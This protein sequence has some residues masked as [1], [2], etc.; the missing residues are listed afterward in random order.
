MVVR[1]VPWAIAGLLYVDPAQGQQLDYCNIA[2]DYYSAGAATP[3]DDNRT[4]AKVFDPGE[5]SQGNYRGNAVVVDGTLGLLLTPR[6]VALQAIEEEYGLRAN[7]AKLDLVFRD[8][9]GPSNRETTAT[10]IA[11]LGESGTN[12]NIPK[13]NQ[14]RDLALLQVEDPELRQQMRERRIAIGPFGTTYDEAL[15]QSFFANSS[16]LIEDKGSLSPALFPSDSTEML[17]TYR[18]AYHSEGGDSGAPLTDLDSQSLTLGVILQKSSDLEK[19]LGLVMPARCLRDPLV[20]WMEKL[21]ED[22]VTKTAELLVNATSNELAETLRSVDSATRPTNALLHAAIRKIVSV[23]LKV[24]EEEGSGP[25]WQPRDDLATFFMRRDCIL[26]RALAG[27]E[28]DLPPQERES[29]EIAWTELTRQLASTRNASAGD[30][31]FERAQLLQSTDPQRSRELAL[32]ASVVYADA[33]GLDVTK[34]ST[35]L[36]SV[37]Q[38]V[39]TTPSLQAALD[40]GDATNIARQFKGLSDSLML[41]ANLSNDSEFRLSAFATARG[42]S[43]QAVWLSREEAPAIASNSLIAY[44]DAS[45]NLGDWGDAKVGYVAAINTPGLETS[46]RDRALD[47]LGYV[48]G[49]VENVSAITA[50][51]RL[52]IILDSTE[53]PDRLLLGGQTTTGITPV[54]LLGGSSGIISISPF[55]A[56]DIRNFR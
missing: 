41:A 43:L 26:D 17:C 27:R 9:E 45:A 12:T 28:A 37:P 24:D 1:C 18:L 36:A 46:V 20:S 10:I 47:D 21:F 3:F 51:Q 5:R 33:I 34:E 14:A 56:E 55:I 16:S 29:F 32:F 11:V 54:Q 42:A 30:S 40:A 6:H 50:A 35:T 48:A 7:G 52:Q 23:V 38:F 39:A 31:I 19:G 53:I 4:I 25:S 44:S 2:A 15:V 8:F 22:E 49:R 13:E